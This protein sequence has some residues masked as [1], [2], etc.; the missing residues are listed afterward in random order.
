MKLSNCE[1]VRVS[2]GVVGAPFQWPANIVPPS[3]NFA[4]D[5]GQDTYV[6]TD[7]SNNGASSGGTEP[8]LMIY[9]AACATEGP[10][11]DST[12]GRCRGVI[13]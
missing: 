4:S 12:T 13:Q 1:G 3:D 8:H 7:C 5:A 11:F 6:E 10:W 9:S 2:G